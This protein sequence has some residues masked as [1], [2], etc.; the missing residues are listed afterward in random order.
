[1][2]LAIASIEAL[3]FKG[4]LRPGHLCRVT[5]EEAPGRSG[6][7][8]RVWNDTTVFAVGRLRVARPSEL[9]P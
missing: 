6:A 9:P 2:P 4:L 3:K 1:V 5:V 8:F 7:D